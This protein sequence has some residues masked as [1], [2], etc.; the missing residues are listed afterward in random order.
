MSFIEQKLLE[1]ILSGVAVALAFP[2]GALIAI[3]IPY[4]PS[5][6]ALFAVFGAGIFLSAIMLLIQET[7]AIGNVYDLVL[8]FALG[9]AT[10]GV[11]VHYTKHGVAVDDNGTKVRIPTK[12]SEGK[13][14]IIGTILD[15]VPESLFIGILISLSEP[16]LIPAII[17]VFLGNL[18]TTL[19]G[20]KIMHHHGLEN[21]IILRDWFLDFFIVAAAAPIGYFLSK[22]SPGEDIP[23]VV[24]SFAAGTLIVF[25]SGELIAR[26][27][28]ESTGHSE[29]LA[30][31]L[32]FL[33]G[34]ILLF[35]I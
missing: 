20:A 17:V 19:E 18:S 23:A 4:S 28:R 1:T 16:G 8:G 11:A 29:D 5:K 13:L 15:S 10:F 24:L 3:Y 34:V 2:I 31:S 7:L 21:K 12:G 22:A 32:G 33:V 14:S 25:I 6:R 27:Y 26:A 35:V 30:I 9:A